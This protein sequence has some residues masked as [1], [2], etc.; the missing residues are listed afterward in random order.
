MFIHVFPQDILW[1]AGVSNFFENNEFAG[2]KVNIPQTMAGV[3]LTPEIGMRWNENHRIFAGFDAMYEYGSDKFTDFIN[4]VVYYEFA[5]KKWR[6]YSGAFPRKLALD[7]YPRMF[8]RDSIQNFRP[9]VTGMFWEYFAD[10]NYANVWLDWVSRQTYAKREAFFLGWSGRYNRNVFYGQHFGYMLHFAGMMEPEIDEGLHDN[11]LLLTSI[12]IDLASKT[13]FEKLEANVGWAVGLER[14]RSIEK[15]HK[16]QGLLSE[17]I[18]E[19]RGLELYNTLYK[20]SGQQIFYADHGNELYWG[21]PMYRTDFYNR[22]DLSILFY[23]SD[24]V[25]LKMTWSLHF[26]ERTTYHSQLFTASFEL[27]NLKKK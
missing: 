27:D 18:V 16:P 7:K 20:G 17:L 11:I 2:S 22:T 23:K 25:N 21:D 10:R 26:A 9:T 5:G 13:N 6:F 19:Y 15:L 24:V 14:D 4:P 8:F 12:G 1:K 3:H